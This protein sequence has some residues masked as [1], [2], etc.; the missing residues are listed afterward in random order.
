[1]TKHFCICSNDS[2][3]KFTDGDRQDHFQWIWMSMNTHNKNHPSD[4]LRSSYETK[5]QLRILLGNRKRIKQTELYNEKHI[6]SSA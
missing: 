2:L 3:S 1:M 5:M 4:F 6:K